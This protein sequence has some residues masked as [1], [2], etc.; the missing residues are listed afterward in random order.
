MPFKTWI[1]NWVTILAASILIIMIAKRL[2]PE[3]S[4]RYLGFY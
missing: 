4:K 3:F 2:F 1:A